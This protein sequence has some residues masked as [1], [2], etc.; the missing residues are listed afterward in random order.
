MPM[1]LST[2][3]LDR[4]LVPKATEGDRVFD[5]EDPVEGRSHS[6]EWVRL[7]S[8]YPPEQKGFERRRSEGA[9]VGHSCWQRLRVRVEVRMASALRKRASI[10]IEAPSAPA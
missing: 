4:P 3:E 2:A 6:S 8:R 1:H 5:V 7:S 10:V 9:R